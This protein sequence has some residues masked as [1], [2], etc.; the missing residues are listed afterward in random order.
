MIIPQWIEFSE[1]GKTCNH[2]RMEIIV[3]KY[4]I[5]F[6]EQR[7]WLGAK[8]LTQTFLLTRRTCGYI[9]SGWVEQASPIVLTTLRMEAPHAHLRLSP[10]PLSIVRSRL[11]VARSGALGIPWSWLLTFS[12]GLKFPCATCEVVGGRRRS[13]IALSEPLAVWLNQWSLLCT[14]CVCALVRRRCRCISIDRGPYVARIGMA[15]QP[16]HQEISG[17]ALS[18]RM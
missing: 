17:V 15:L 18:N 16:W 12:A 2:D 9:H 3:W 13:L 1:A 6:T 10:S 8:Q 5:F 4:I 14:S 7:R 11:L